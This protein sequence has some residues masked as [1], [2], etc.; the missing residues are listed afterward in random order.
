MNAT[1]LDPATATSNALSSLLFIIEPILLVLEFHSL[2]H[3][4]KTQR[5]IHSRSLLHL[6]IQVNKEKGCSSSLLLTV[7]KRK[8]ERLLT[9]LF[10]DPTP[11]PEP[12]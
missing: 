6:F 3:Q 10:S 5:K 2:I 12:I 11:E 9:Y 4:V 7:G 1:L 8:R